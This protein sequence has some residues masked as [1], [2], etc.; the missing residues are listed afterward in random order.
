[1]NG[2]EVSLMDETLNEYWLAGMVFA[3][4][5]L[6]GSWIAAKSGLQRGNEGRAHLLRLIELVRLAKSGSA[7]E[8][9]GA[10]DELEEMTQWLLAQLR[11]GD[12]ELGKF[13]CIEPIITQLR[14][15][16]QTRRKDLATRKKPLSVV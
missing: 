14:A 8:L 5:V 7:S 6:V 12:I 11:A 16:I 3:F 10:D 9:A 1:L 4:V 2:E 15:T 13:Q